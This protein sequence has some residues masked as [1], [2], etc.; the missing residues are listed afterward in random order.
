[1]HLKFMLGP[2]LKYTLKKNARVNFK[3]TL[4]F[5]KWGY[6]K[7]PLGLNVK[8]V[9]KKSHE[10]KRGGRSSRRDRATYGHSSSEQL[11]T[12]GEYLRHHGG[13]LN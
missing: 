10:G 13:L 3:Y 4:Q 9:F 8:G 6:L 2:Y 5:P 7:N 12:A 11:F 1:M